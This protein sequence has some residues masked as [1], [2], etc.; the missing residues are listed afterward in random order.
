[1]KK[2]FNEET[3]TNSCSAAGEAK[4]QTIFR[5]TLASCSFQQGGLGPSLS[6]LSKRTP[7]GLVVFFF[8]FKLSYLLLFIYFFVIVVEGSTQ[9]CSGLRL[10][11]VGLGILMGCQRSNPGINM[12]GKYS[13]CC[14][15]A[16][17]PNILYFCF[18]LELNQLYSGFSLGTELM[19]HSRWSSGG[20]QAMLGIKPAWVHAQQ[21][22]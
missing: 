12:Q 4:D 13:I 16:P 17:A 5:Q 15:L 19:D 1:M 6:S 9:L 20:Q 18:V 21:M 14:T 3:K 2:L 7:S 11:L 22:P 8:F 10:F